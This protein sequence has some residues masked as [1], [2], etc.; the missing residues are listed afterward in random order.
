MNVNGSCVEL[1]SPH[2][3]EAAG[4]GRAVRW[5]TGDGTSDRVRG[6]DGDVQV[7]PDR[8]RAEARRTGPPDIRGKLSVARW[9]E[10]IGTHHLLNTY[11][12]CGGKGRRKTGMV[13]YLVKFMSFQFFS[14]PLLPLRGWRLG[15]P[16]DSCEIPKGGQESLR[17]ALS[18]ELDARHFGAQCGLRYWLEWALRLWVCFFPTPGM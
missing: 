13:P 6:R 14:V 3:G 2:F 8:I 12:G 10:A 9:L 11:H 17:K 4:K 1:T 7:Y 15:R 16:R 18:W 5:G